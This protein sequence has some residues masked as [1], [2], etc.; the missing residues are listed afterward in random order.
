MKYTLAIA[1]TLFAF[2]CK[3]KGD[4]GDSAGGDADADTDADTDADSEVVLNELQAGD[5]AGGS[6]WVEILNTGASSADLS[7]WVLTDTAATGG[8]SLQLPAGTSLAPGARL[9]VW[10]DDGAGTEPGPHAP[11]KLSGLGETLT[12]QNA[13]GATV[14]ETTFPALEDDTVW[15]RTPDGGP[16]WEVLTTPTPDA[17]NP[18]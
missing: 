15:A 10:C 17:P 11:F 3:D 6:D 13:A 14:D 7:D 1:A 4:T 8:P 18:G 16:T 5:T 9:L 12:L 2:A